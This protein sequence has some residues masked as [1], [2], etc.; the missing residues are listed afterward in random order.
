MEQHDSPG[1]IDRLLQIETVLAHLQHDVDSLNRSLATH[2]RRL[3]EIDDRFG[4]I[5]Q[6]LQIN[7]QEPEKR[8]PAAERPPHY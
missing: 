7:G 1:M 3:Q 5:E 4:R 8:D 6:E 2:F